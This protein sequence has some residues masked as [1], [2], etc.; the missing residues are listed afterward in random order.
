MQDARTRG[1]RVAIAVLGC[2]L[3]GVGST[4][5]VPAN[6]E[7]LPLPAQ[8]AI[9]GVLGRDNRA[10]HAT[11]QGQALHMTNPRHGLAA[12]FTEAGVEIRHGDAQV[13]L[14]WR[15]C[16]YG[17]V[18]SAGP[19]VAPEARDNRV[20]YRRGAVTEWYVNGP[21][22][23]QQGFTLLAP[24]GPRTGAPLTLV[25]A[26]SG[27]LHARVEPGE[28]GLT[29]SSADGTTVL[30]YRGLTAWDASGRALP[31][32][33]QVQGGELRL[34]VED[35]GARYPLVVDPFVEQAKLTASDGAAV[36][37]FG[38]SVAISGDTVVVG[39]VGADINANADQGSAYVFVKPVGGW[40]TASTFNAKL[41]ASDGAAGDAFGGSVAISGDTVVVGAVGANA[42]QGAAYVFVKP[43][44]GWAGALTETAKLIASD[45]AAGDQFGISVGVSGDTVVVGAF[46]DDIGANSEQ[47][48]AYVFVKP[49]GGWMNMTQTAKLTASDGAFNDNFGF[50]VAVSGDTVVVGA[51][52][53]DIGANSDQG[54]AYVFVK[55]VGGWM[56]MTQ[57]AKLTASDGA[58][59]DGFGFSVAV[60]GDTAVVGA[61]GDTI[62]ANTDQGSAYVFGSVV[63]GRPAPALSK[64]AQLGIVALLLLVGLLS[65]RRR[66]KSIAPR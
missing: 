18:S 3:T 28:T 65:L 56:N 25:L 7:T 13:A 1:A 43:V 33:L 44:G 27:T 45:G 9:S 40:A 10:Y 51:F 5:A 8:A 37:G 58:A 2:V 36:D 11:S 19:A 32:R 4:L 57:T 46:L 66:G 31:A 48:S 17:T 12:E 26:L 20:E 42:N 62:G 21:W 59:G 64:S 38:S 50:S 49:V 55:P 24:P 14:A 34:H 52:L 30:A 60:S 54:S 23:L 41:T 47:G 61:S 15:G 63:V 16:G 39:A 22:G 29:L 35:A 53:D 6:Q